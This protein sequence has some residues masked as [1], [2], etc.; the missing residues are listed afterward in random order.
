MPG[1]CTHYCFAKSLESQ[2][3]CFEPFA[4]GAQGP[5]PFFFRAFYPNPFIR[6]RLKMSMYGSYLHRIDP[7]DLWVKMI[8]F[9]KEDEELYM[10]VVGLLA[11]YC[12]DRV[13]HPY[14]YYR[15]GFDENGHLRHGFA[16]YHLYLE[17]LLDRHMLNQHGIDGYTHEFIKAPKELTK[18]ISMIYVA[19]DPERTSKNCYHHALTTWRIANRTLKSKKGKKRKFWKIFGKKSMLYAF[20]LPSDTKE[21][22]ALD[23]A[24]LSHHEWKNPD[25][26]EIHHES[27][28]DLFLI[29]SQQFEEGKAIFDRIR[30]GEEEAKEDLRRFVASQDHSGTRTGENKKEFNQF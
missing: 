16:Y 2:V 8:D 20:S 3:T 30:N 22:D 15:T 28:D 13:F 19:A 23:V 26:L 7:T 9:T 25:T 27:T 12:V 1:I 18:R 24:N 17:A 29:A 5:D 11:H 6:R 10:Y 14:V 21:G 4:L